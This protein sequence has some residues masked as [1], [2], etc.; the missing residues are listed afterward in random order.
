VQKVSYGQSI[1]RIDELFLAMAS[2]VEEAVRKASHAMKRQDLEL[3]KS[4]KK[5]DSVIDD[6]QQTIEDTVVETIATQQPVASDLRQLMSATKLASDF[7]RAGD[8][9]VHLAKATKFFVN[10]PA[11][12]QLENLESMAEI[13]CLM[14]RQTARAY[15]T[16]DAALARNTATLDDGIDHIHKS[17]LCEILLFLHDH[18]GQAEQ[19]SKIITVSGYLE[20]LGDHMTNACEA[21]VFMVEGIHTELNE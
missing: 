16:R 8:Y 14:I 3:A 21:I 4:V 15:S 1:A 11:W 7:E 20:R 10:E 9:A 5:G 2:A 19:A 12:R 17:V 6:L 13:G 18:P